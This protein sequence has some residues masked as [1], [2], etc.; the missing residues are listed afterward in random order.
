[1]LRKGR[2]SI[3]WV[4]KQQILVKCG[5]VN[6]E[7]TENNGRI[8]GGIPVNP[9]N[10]YPFQVGRGGPLIILRSSK[11]DFMN[12]ILLSIKKLILGA[13]VYFFNIVV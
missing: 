8:V 3:F 11:Q 7:D 13:S 9:N 5:V 12:M 4:K 1:M 10:K 6:A 2:R